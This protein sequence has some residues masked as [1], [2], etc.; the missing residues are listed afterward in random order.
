[1]ARIG[2]TYAD[3]S[4]A[5]SAVKTAGLEPTVDRV[6]EQL[7]TG[8]KSTIGPL[9]KRWRNSH[10][11]AEHS[12]SLP[13]ELLALVQS[14][15]DKIQTDAESKID[16]ARSGFEA[17]RVEL[18]QTLQERTDENDRLRRENQELD[19]QTRALDENNSALSQTL[20]YARIA[21]AKS[22][23][24]LEQAKSR[25]EDL[26]LSIATLKQDRQDL[27]EHFEHYQQHSADE[28]QQIRDQL[29]L[30]NDQNTAVLAELSQAQAKADE[31][32]RAGMLALA[33]TQAAQRKSDAQES[34]ITQLRQ[35]VSFTKEQSESIADSARLQQ[36][37]LT[38]KLKLTTDQL[39]TSRE[40]EEHL[41]QEVV[42]I[43]QTL[44]IETQRCNA[45]SDEK[46]QVLI[47]IALAQ[48]ELKQL[49]Q[50]K[51]DL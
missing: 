51:N 10:A 49:Q 27:R 28:R 43:K 38:E 33:D 19:N 16:E 32:Q 45:L 37:T 29:D 26:K 8:S 34:E 17:A 48:G 50:I 1:M 35:Q 24:Q 23:A 39:R 41:K 7:G 47:E 21:G 13:P 5:A 25:I 44:S 12:D 11:G 31:L 3:V 20:E 36:Q 15:Y 6:R 22:E 42:Q 9:L 14:L 4:S 2:V 40:N 18:E 30:A 46:Q